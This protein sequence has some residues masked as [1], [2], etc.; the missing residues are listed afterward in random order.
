MNASAGLPYFI[1]AGSIFVIALYV[2]PR[3]NIPNLLIRG[4]VPAYM[5]ELRL[6]HCRWRDKETCLAQIRVDYGPRERF[7][8]HLLII[9]RSV[10]SPE[11]VVRFVNFETHRGWKG[12]GEGKTQTPAFSSR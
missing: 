10:K 5:D 2:K 12:K 6:P 8:R 7:V 1:V 3:T 11:V 4:K 9:V